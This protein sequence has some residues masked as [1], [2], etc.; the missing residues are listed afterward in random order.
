MSHHAHSNVSS[1]QESHPPWNFSWV[2]ENELAAMAWPKTKAN[3]NFLWQNGIRHLVTLSP[4]MV[5]PIEES[6]MKWTLIPVVEFEPPTIEDM[7]AFISICE[8]SLKKKEAVG[9]HCRMGWGRTGVMAACFLVRFQG[10]GPERAV[11][12]L[13]RQR[14]GSVETYEQ[15]K[16]V[17]KY[18]DFIMETRN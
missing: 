14:P 11:S 18:H 8:A 9:V 6:D 1:D 2:I 5:P 12:N 16:A 17:V 15:E 13:R 10:L 4:E 7:V 3:L